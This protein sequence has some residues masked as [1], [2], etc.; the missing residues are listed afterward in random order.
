MP[1]FDFPIGTPG[2]NPNAPDPRKLLGPP[3]ATGAATPGGSVLGLPTPQAPAPAAAQA[4]DPGAQP[5]GRL[6]ALFRQLGDF[7]AGFQGVPQQGPTN[8]M[9]QQRLQAMQAKQQKYRQDLAILG[10]M[11][12]QLDKAPISQQEATRANL[13]RNFEAYYGPGGDV[14]FDGFLGEGS[15]KALLEAAKTDD[16]LNTLIVSDAPREVIND[17]IKSPERLARA[18]A[19]ADEAAYP[20]VRDRLR[21]LLNSTDPETAKA[22]AEAREDGNLTAAEVES[23][24]DKFGTT[25]PD[26]TQLTRAE[27]GTLKRLQGKLAQ[28]LPGFTTDEEFMKNRE[29]EAELQRKIRL[30]NAKA[31]DD[32]KTDPFKRQI[33]LD[34]YKQGGKDIEAANATIDSLGQLKT[35]LSRA[36]KLV[37]EG[38]VSTGRAVGS[39]PVTFARKFLPGTASEDDIN[40]VEKAFGDE[41]VQT[42]QTFVGKGALSDREGA[43]LLKT[44]GGMTKGE[45]FNAQDLQD[46]IDLLTNIIERKEMER[47]I[48][49]RNRERIA[50]EAGLGDV[51]ETKGNP[52]GATTPS[53]LTPER[54]QSLLEKY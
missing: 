35:S 36:K 53:A 34:A 50:E 3:S 44:T 16:A 28:E 21:S 10:E 26:G 2:I 27:R 17:Y 43:A 11:Q 15:S 48:A 24:L 5:E 7:G 1:L 25:G 47:G 29:A 49:T 41:W 38:T 46:R 12:E 23:L 54:K 6:Q 51:L 9:R 22:V 30:E 20:V 40:T 45:G 13:K 14:F 31:K 19:A 18:Q 52:T 8:M 32:P 37:G 4:S 39:A 42:V 33:A